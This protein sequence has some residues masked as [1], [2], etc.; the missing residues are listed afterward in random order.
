MSEK[1][2]R[3]NSNKIDYTILPLAGRKERARAWMRGEIK[4]DR[5]NWKKLW[6]DDTILVCMQCLLR[7]ATALEEGEHIDP[8]TGVSHAALIGCNVDMIIEWQKREGILL[9][10]EEFNKRLDQAREERRLKDK[11]AAMEAEQERAEDIEFLNLLD[12][13]EAAQARKMTMIKDEYEM[14]DT[15]VVK[16]ANPEDALKL[17]PAP[18]NTRKDG[19]TYYVRSDGMI[20]EV[21]EENCT[22]T[23]KNCT[24]KE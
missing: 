23:C 5:D 9:S 17:K 18:A 8:E 4:Y 10:D 1:A 3:F 14:T 19:V 16:L 7:H 21:V 24:C 11:L 6:G 15:G 22:G 2:K 20:E 13:F 12:E